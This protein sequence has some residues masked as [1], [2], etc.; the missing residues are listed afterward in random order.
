VRISQRNA[1]RVSFRGL[2]FVVLLSSV[3]VLVVR[4]SHASA[5]DPGPRGGPPGAGGP[6]SGLS[7][8]ESQLFMDGQETIQEIDSVKE[9]FPIPAWVSAQGTTW[10]D[11]AGATTSLRPEVL[12]HR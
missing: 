11:V 4:V 5:V 1:L 6:V 7:S 3:S 8:S 12:V 10:M 9:R 2:M